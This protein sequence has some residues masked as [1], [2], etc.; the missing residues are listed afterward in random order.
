MA[1]RIDSP[2]PLVVGS[3][4]GALGLAHE[5]MVEIIEATFL[6]MVVNLFVGVAT[7]LHLFSPSRALLTVLDVV[8]ACCLVAMLFVAV[9]V[10]GR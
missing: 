7:R 2:T 3:I 10:F 5:F 1:R 6:L 8:N 9:D 4:I